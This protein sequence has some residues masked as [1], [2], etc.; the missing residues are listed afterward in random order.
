MHVAT[1]KDK[2]EHEL[3]D[4][5]HLFT[6]SEHFVVNVNVLSHLQSHKECFILKENCCQYILLIVQQQLDN[7]L[8]ESSDE[9]QTMNHELLKCDSEFLENLA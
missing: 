2:V 6:F 1:S 5:Q 4:V 9:D 3:L 7:H 8:I